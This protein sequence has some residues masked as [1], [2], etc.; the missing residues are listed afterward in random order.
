MAKTICILL[1]D[2]DPEDQ[3]ILKDYLLK[4]DSSLWIH[5]VL[6][7]KEAISWL[8]GRPD[9]EVPSLII[10]DYKMPLLNAIETLDQLKEEPR[11][12]SIPK[13]VWSTSVQTEHKKLC[14]ERGAIAYF[15]KPARTRDLVNL[16]R[17]MLE[18]IQPHHDQS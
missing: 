6:N 4:E 1:A 10:L 2:D 5:C 13:V 18:I 8:K 9:E 15:S 17:K 14:L 12:L 3:D 16:A 11:Y 7:G